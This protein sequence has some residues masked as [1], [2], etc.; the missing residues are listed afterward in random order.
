[1]LEIDGESRAVR[2]GDAI[3]IPPG[4]RHELTAGAEGA[5]LLCICVPPYSNDD[6]YFS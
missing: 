6:T 1:M 4:A 2:P 5:R 3:V